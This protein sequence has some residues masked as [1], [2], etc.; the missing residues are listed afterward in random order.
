[1]TDHDQAG[2]TIEVFVTEADEGDL[3]PSYVDG[4]PTEGMP[5]IDM[6]D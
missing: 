4:T 3:V 5:P 6:F 2:R 1:M